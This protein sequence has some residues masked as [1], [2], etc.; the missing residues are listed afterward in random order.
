MN[1][2]NKHTKIYGSF[3]SDPGNNG[4][5]FFNARFERDNINAIYKSFYSDNIGDSVFAA[6]VL[7]FGGFAVSMPFKTEVLKYVDEIDPVAQTIGAANTVVNNDG[8]LR[9]YNT[10]WLGAYNFFKGKDLSHVN[11]IG[12]G[13]FAR[14][15]VFA[16]T[17]LG[18][19]F[20][21]VSRKD[22]PTINEVTGQYFINA[23]P[24][25]IQSEVNTIFDGRGF[26]EAGQEISKLQ[27]EEQY[28]IYRE[29]M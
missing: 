23:T 7:K 13:G 22:I 14:A 16:L 26:A 10:D 12:T 21:I 19:N 24:A 17:E 20:S 18:L 4:S 28:K 6:K 27:A 29:W 3:S 2:I 15:I 1:T 25:D 5:I 11:V 9:A 8:Y